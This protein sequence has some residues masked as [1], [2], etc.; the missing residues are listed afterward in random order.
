MSVLSQLPLTPQAASYLGTQISAVIYFKAQ[1]TGFSLPDTERAVAGKI[2]EYME[3]AWGVDPERLAQLTVGL[4]ME[5][6]HHFTLELTVEDEEIQKL[7]D[8]LN[9]EIH[10]IMD[11]SD[12]AITD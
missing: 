1:M 3:A 7:F 9:K 10:F 12:D 11:T 5:L 2:V 4:T 6:H 8:I